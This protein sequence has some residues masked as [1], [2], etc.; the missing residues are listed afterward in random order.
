ILTWAR[1]TAGLSLEEAAHALDIKSTR[2]STGTERL[3]AFEAGEEPSRAVLL[4][5]A[6]VYRR[7]LLVFYLAERP[8]IGDRGQDFRTVAG[9]KPFE[10][11]LDTLIRDI[12]ARQGIVRSIV[13]DAA[14]TPIDFIGSVTMATTFSD[15]SVKV[16]ARLQFS[17]AEF[18]ASR[19]PDEA[20]AYLRGKI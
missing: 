5:M 8:R 11:D 20:F 13:E 7:S 4:K 12:K 9:H 19:N 2:K 17:L 16:A 14:P 6:R 3:A 10:A 1:E 15:L 18:R